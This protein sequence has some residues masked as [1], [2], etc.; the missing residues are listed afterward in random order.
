M[1]YFSPCEHVRQKVERDLDR[2]EPVFQVGYSLVHHVLAGVDVGQDLVDVVL[3]LHER[4][5]RDVNRLGRPRQ[6]KK[7]LWDLQ[8]NLPCLKNLEKPRIA[9][10]MESFFSRHKK[11]FGFWM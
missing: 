7:V 4:D 3:S 1:L 11:I 8:N 2:V 6:K 5:E 10:D 9:K